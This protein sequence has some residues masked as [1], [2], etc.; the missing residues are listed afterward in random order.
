MKKKDRKALARYVRWAA[1]ELGL[2]DWTVEVR[3]GG[4]EERAFASVDPTEGRRYAVITFCDEFR[5]LTLDEQRNAVVHELLHC[6]HAAATD[7]VRLDVCQQMSQA[8]YDVMFGGFK[9]QIE[10]M[11]DALADAFAPHLAHIDWPK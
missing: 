11:V 1:N 7:I 8:A 9:R 2:R 3:A 6:H 5:Q 4:C 10:Y